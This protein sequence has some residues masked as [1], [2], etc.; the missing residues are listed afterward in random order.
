VKLYGGKIDGATK[1][2]LLEGGAR[3]LR[4]AGGSRDDVDLSILK[5]ERN[6]VHVKDIWEG[7]SVLVSV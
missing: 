3:S 6:E 2:R 5:Q 1:H 4:A 7:L